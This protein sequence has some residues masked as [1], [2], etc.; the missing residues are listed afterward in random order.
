M[1]ALGGAR[2]GS[3]SSHRAVQ[4]VPMV[5][6]WAS[7][8][9]VA[10]LDICREPAV[11]VVDC[12]AQDSDLEQSIRYLT[13]HIR[14]LQ[15][16]HL[17]S[18]SD[19]IPTLVMEA[20]EELDKL[21]LTM[22][23]PRRP[24]GSSNSIR[25]EGNSVATGSDC[26]Q[27]EVRTAEEEDLALLQDIPLQNLLGACFEQQERKSRSNS[28][29]VSEVSTMASLGGSSMQPGA[30]PSMSTRP[31]M[32]CFSVDA[33]SP[34]SVL[35]TRTTPTSSRSPCSSA[36][37]QFDAKLSCGSPRD[38]LPCPSSRRH[39]DT[40]AVGSI[41]IDRHDCIVPDKKSVSQFPNFLTKYEYTSKPA[42]LKRAPAN[43]LIAVEPVEQDEDDDAWEL[44][45]LK[46]AQSD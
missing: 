40:A 2:H 44:E 16:T 12:G 39:S 25:G 46:R 43:A 18:Q 24:M 9:G 11:P 10:A 8:H 45:F 14:V 31:T 32:P 3:Q 15:Q 36:L 27:E 33:R 20:Q 38:F 30:S 37:P 28:I 29:G 23:S 35:D 17:P 34:R 42:S 5:Q 41:I 1:A 6:Q 19:A 22:H 7:L 13:E 4:R 26:L 21:A